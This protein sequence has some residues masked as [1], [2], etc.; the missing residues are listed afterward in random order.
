MWNEYNEGKT[1][2]G[3]LAKAVDKIETIIQHNQGKLPDGFDF[4]FN[5]NYGTQYSW[6]DDIIP[7]IREIVDGKTKEQ[8]E[9]ASDLDKSQ[10]K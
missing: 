7:K 4:E 3:C 6:C 2:E 5:L 8:I 10:I 9:K 1:R